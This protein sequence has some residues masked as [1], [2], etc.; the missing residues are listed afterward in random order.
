M[1]FLQI[2]WSQVPPSTFLAQDICADDAH[3]GLEFPFIPLPGSEP[4]IHREVPL[5]LR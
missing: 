4:H 1:V 5:M 2:D 3:T